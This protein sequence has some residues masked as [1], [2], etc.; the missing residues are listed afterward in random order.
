[1]TQSLNNQGKRLQCTFRNAAGALVNP[2]DIDLKVY[3]EWQGVTTEVLSK[4]KADLTT[5]STGVFYYDFIPGT[6]GAGR[7]TARF[8][9]DTG[10][11]VEQS[12]DVS[13]GIT[14]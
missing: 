4:L 3:R 2:A 8:T 13:E 11:D 7:Y 9:T 14:V 12:W 6:N 1:M 10:V 5:P